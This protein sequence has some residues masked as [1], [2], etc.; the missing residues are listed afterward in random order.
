MKT[1]GHD[2]ENVEDHTKDLYPERD[3]KVIDEFGEIPTTPSRLISQKDSWSMKLHKKYKSNE[4]NRSVTV[5]ISKTCLQMTI[6]L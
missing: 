6:F 1:L 5:L 3:M 2:L 4:K